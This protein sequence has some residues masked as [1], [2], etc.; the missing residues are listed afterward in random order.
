MMTD[1]INLNKI[2]GSSLEEELKIQDLN[3]YMDR[4]S[5]Q[6]FITQF[7]DHLSKAYIEVQFDHHTGNITNF[8]ILERE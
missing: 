3:Q 4:S 2:I 8:E 7:R 6:T 5:F 1:K